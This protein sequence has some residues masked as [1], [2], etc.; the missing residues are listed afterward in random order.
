MKRRDLA[1]AVVVA[2]T[3]L[4]AAAVWSVS[5]SNVVVHWGTDGTADA[6][7]PRPIA[8]LMVPALTVAAYLLLRRGVP[9]G[10][11]AAK[12]DLEPVALGAT[13]A[14]AVLQLPI[15][16]S[17]AGTTTHIEGFMFTLGL[18][19]SLLGSGLGMVPPNHVFGVR[20]PWTYA[21]RTSWVR[22][23]RLTSRLAL[24]AGPALALAATAN[25]S[26][27][28]GAAIIIAVASAS[29]AIVYSY[30]VWRS[31]PERVPAIGAGA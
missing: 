3:L 30:L 20:T 11:A 23:H 4:A 14:V 31:D 29:A 15:V 8:L 7:A 24:V 10:S 26:L 1:A 2:A 5:P 18:L 28:T 22:T 12:S 16:L 17:A 13:L 9:G 19:I 25:S 21:S 6:V 27:A